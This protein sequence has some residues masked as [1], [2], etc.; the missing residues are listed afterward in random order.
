MVSDKMIY[1]AFRTRVTLYKQNSLENF[2][3]LLYLPNLYI[4]FKSV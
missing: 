4:G 3:I 1:S 2:F